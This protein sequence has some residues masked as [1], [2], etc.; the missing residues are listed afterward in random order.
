MNY[1]DKHIGDWIR[2][3]VS[4]TM[5]E[6]GAYNRLIDQVYQTE[7][8]LPADKKE[9]YRLARASSLP[10]RKAV[11][12][13]LDKFFDLSSDGYMQ[14]RAQAVIEEYWDREPAKDAKRE[15]EKIRQQRSRA[16]RKALFD[17]LRDLGVTP[18]FNVSMRTLEAELSRVTQHSESQFGHA[19]VTRDDTATQT[20]IP[21]TQY[22]DLKPKG[23]DHTTTDQPELGQA[24]VGAVVTAAGKITMAMRPFGIRA[25]PGSLI[26]Q[27]LAEQGVTAET[28]TAACEEAKRS[29]PNDPIG[30][31]YI[32]KIVERW[33]REAATLNVTGATQPR[34]SPRQ[35]GQ[36]NTQRLLDRIN[37][38]PKNEPDDRIIDINDRPA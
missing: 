7:R 22:P 4:L 12:Y 11:D 28:I 26:I 38:K 6:D 20:P 14:K 8:A 13:V 36:A 15:N 21:N 34:A 19:S 17:Q 1:Y 23:S 31:A 5:L 10:E 16:R 3:T 2:D 29:Q 25:N 24:P 27:R 18:E 37:G 32:V 35:A 9:V 33:A 30:P